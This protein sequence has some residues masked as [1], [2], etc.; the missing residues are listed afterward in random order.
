MVLKG[1]E[2]LSWFSISIPYHDIM[3][4]A[5]GTVTAAKR[6]LQSPERSSPSH[7]VSGRETQSD[8]VMWRTFL[9]APYRWACSTWLG[10]PPLPICLI[11]NSWFL[12][13]CI[14][15]NSFTIFSKI[16]SLAGTPIRCLH[17]VWHNLSIKNYTPEENNFTSSTAFPG[18][19]SMGQEMFK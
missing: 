4:W 17:A 15:S 19:L 10:D 6:G 9:F 3:Q 18:N 1:G 16:V 14:I 13:Y 2:L 8:V 7:V 11:Y 5:D 12:L